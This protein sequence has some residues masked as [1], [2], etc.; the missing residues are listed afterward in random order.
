MIAIR[1]IV[2]VVLHLVAPA[3]VARLGFK[4]RWRRA[5]VVLLA[6]NIVDLDHL[7]ASPVYDPNRCSIGLHPL[8]STIPVVLY[9]ALAIWPKT[10]IVGIGLLLHMLLDLGDCLWMGF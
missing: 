6:V 4:A 9:G 10:R 3:A 2:H 8:H 1:P 7:F 5:L